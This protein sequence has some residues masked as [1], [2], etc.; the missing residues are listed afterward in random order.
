MQ[1]SKRTIIIAIVAVIV[2]GPAAYFLTAPK[3][4]PAKPQATA[5]TTQAKPAEQ[6]KK[7]ETPAAKGEKAKVTKAKVAPSEKPSKAPATKGK[8]ASEK[9]P[10]RVTKA[11]GEEKKATEKK[12]IV[13]AAPKKETLSVVSIPLPKRDPFAR[14]GAPPPAPKSQQTQQAPAGQAATQPQQVPPILTPPQPSVTTSGAGQPAMA[15]SPGGYGPQSFAAASSPGLWYPR[16][17]PERAT[18][19]GKDLQLVGTVRGA[20]KAI[21]TFRYGADGTARPYN[22]REGE[23]VGSSRTKVR[24]IKTGQVVLSNDFTHEVVPVEQKESQ[25][26]NRSR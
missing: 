13:A 17:L 19:P 5:S 25:H 21:A 7:A 11:G 24:R 22:V 26:I 6:A 10:V 15:T 16:S 12:T 4:P 3:K 14:I 20:R 2:L 23:R 8:K 18:P 1:D 9:P